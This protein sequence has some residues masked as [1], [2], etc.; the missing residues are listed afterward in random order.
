MSIRKPFRLSQ[1]APNLLAVRSEFNYGERDT[2]EGDG[3]SDIK[4]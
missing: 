2:I 3:S 4:S 1:T